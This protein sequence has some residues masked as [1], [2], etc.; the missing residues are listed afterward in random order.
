MLRNLI[1]KAFT[2]LQKTFTR[3]Q[4]A[5]NKNQNKMSSAD[6]T[7]IKIEFINFRI[8]QKKIFSGTTEVGVNW[9]K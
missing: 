1:Q 5:I 6:Q 3:L 7:L 8:G 2:R 9:R 4:E